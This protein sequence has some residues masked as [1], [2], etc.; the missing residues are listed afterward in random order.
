MGGGGERERERERDRQTDRQTNRQRQSR[1]QHV[2]IR[3]GI[4]SQLGTYQMN[5]AFDPVHITTFLLKSC[6]L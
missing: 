6:V 4:T 2:C 5:P 1:I 3:T